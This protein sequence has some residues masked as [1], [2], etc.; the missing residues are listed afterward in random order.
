MSVKVT[1]TRLTVIFVVSVVLTL[2][3]QCVATNV[4]ASTFDK[5]YSFV[6]RQ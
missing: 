2:L 6:T 4:S 3:L 1:V 5:C